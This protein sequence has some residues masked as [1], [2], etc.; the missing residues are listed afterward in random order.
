MRRAVLEECTIDEHILDHSHHG[1]SG[2]AECEADRTA[3]LDHIGLFHHTFGL[4]ILHV[5]DGRNLGAF[6]QLGLRCVVGIEAAEVIDV[7]L[8]EIETDR[9]VGTQRVRKRHLWCTDFECNHVG[10]IRI[11]HRVHNR[12][13]DVPGGDG[14]PAVSTKNRFE[15]QRGRGLTVRAGDGEPRNIAVFVAQ[16]PGEFEFTPH[17]HATCKCCRDQR[18]RRTKAW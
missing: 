15:H 13:P 7:I 6:V 5:V 18:M 9:R 3:S 11:H 14:M 16:A 12:V 2:C 1:E 17:A 4:R 10:T 8:G